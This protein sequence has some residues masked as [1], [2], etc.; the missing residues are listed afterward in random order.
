VGLVGDPNCAT[1]ISYSNNN[2]FACTKAAT[3]NYFALTTGSP[4]SFQCNDAGSGGLYR[5]ATCPTSGASFTCT[6]I[7]TTTDANTNVAWYLKSASI[8]DWCTHWT[9]GCLTCTSNPSSSYAVTCTGLAGGWWGT[10]SGTITECTDPLC[11]ACTAA[12]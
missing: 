10:P 3:S 7:T 4:L 1:C 5:C 6:T 9:P 11:T 12:N 8:S 2:V